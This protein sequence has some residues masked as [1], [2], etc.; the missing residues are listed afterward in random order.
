MSAA[1]KYQVRST[2]TNGLA[3]Y[4]PTTA[5]KADDLAAYLSGMTDTIEAD[6]LVDNEFRSA[7]VGGVR[8]LW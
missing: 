3:T 2:S 7:Y 6:I 5:G 4:H 8:V 1:T